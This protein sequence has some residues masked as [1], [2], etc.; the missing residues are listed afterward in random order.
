MELVLSHVTKRYDKKTA[1]DDVSL[2]LTP[3][4]LNVFAGEN[5]AGKST[6]AKIIS[7]SVEL[8]SGTIDFT[9]E[10]KI[11]I[12]NQKPLVAESISVKENILLGIKS[13]KENENKL[14]ELIKKWAPRLNL[15]AKVCDTGG[16]ERF[17]TSLLSCLMKE[18]DILLLDE[19]GAYLEEE[20]RKILFKN[21]CELK[22]LKTI[23]LI[24]HDKKELAFYADNIFLLQKGKLIKTYAE[25]NL[26]TKEF[27]EEVVKEIEKEIR[28]FSKDE[29]IAPGDTASASAYSQDN[30]GSANAAHSFTVNNLSCAPIDKPLIKDI[31]FTVK[32]GELTVIKGLAEAGLLTLE[33]CITGMQ[34]CRAEFIFSKNKT[35]IVV[36][37]ISPH[38]LRRALYKKTGLKVSIVP[39]DKTMRGSNP[40]LTIEEL[41][42]EAAV[43]GCS[44]K[45]ARAGSAENGA[46]VDEIINRSGFDILKSQKVKSL[47][48]G[49]LQRL[50]L[51]RELFCKP[52]IL[53]ASEPLAGLDMEKSEII[54][55]R[56]TQLKKDGC[57][58]LVLTT[59]NIPQ[60][61]CDRYYRLEAGRLWKE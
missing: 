6:L 55:D 32:A 22:K 25:L 24:T 4:A 26:K 30:A 9:K 51:E 37:K 49:M 52:D 45:T 60:K 54:L 8:T 38:F 48:G 56:F 15:N 17:Y 44:K 33:D 12:V 39:S 5:G 36:N 61:M 20:E 14:N 13:T 42:Y 58:V 34:E 21:L 46:G 57:A 31:S 41:L 11:V 19:P 3:Y 27:K 50:I 28:T 2:K 1:L 23:I 47:S 35:E 7:G 53:I 59:Q 29:K 43:S 40:E 18:Y 16:G 10:N